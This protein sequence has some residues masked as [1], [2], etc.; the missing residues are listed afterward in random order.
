MSAPRVQ[1]RGLRRE[2]YYGGEEA[3]FLFLLTTFFL[4]EAVVFFLTTVAFLRV[5]G[6]R[7]AC[8]RQEQGKLPFAR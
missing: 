3:H 5:A 6:L 8:S 4:G 7:V 2:E 1:H